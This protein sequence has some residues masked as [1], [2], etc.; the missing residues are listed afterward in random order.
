MD[1][2]IIIPDRSDLRIKDLIESI[3]YYNDEKKTVEIIV[4]LNK[5][6]KELEEL[7]YKIKEQKKD[8][9]K[10]KILNINFCN[11][12]LAYNTGIQNATYEN[13]L[14]LDSDLICRKGSI[15]QMVQEMIEN[16]VLLVK[17]KLLYEQKNNFSNNLVYKS[18]LATTTNCE[19]P[20]IPV[21]LI[22][23]EIFRVLN[24]GYMFAVDTVWCSD[25]DFAYRVLAKKIKIFYSDAVFYH[26]SI[27]LKKDLHDAFLYGLGKGIR[28][29]RTKEKWNPI[30]EVIFITKLGIPE[31]LRIIEFMY[32]FLWAAIQQVACFIQLFLPNKTFF[33]QSLDFEKSAKLED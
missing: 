9:F 30:K 8:K 1:I 29:K 13:I 5:P 7:V 11:L 28:V 4:V 27:G 31:K 19:P 22:K 16:D 15:K 23:K 6:T 25:A 32:L 24:D 33:P 18:R 3:D 10:F 26:A 21:I 20:Y 17:S 2:S 14:F 12:G